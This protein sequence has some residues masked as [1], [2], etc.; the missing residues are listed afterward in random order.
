MQKPPLAPYIL[1]ALAMVGL[2]ITGYLAYFQY[3]N[4]IP[5]CAIGGCAVVLTSSYSKFFGVPW[6]YIGLVYYLYMLC[7]SV[8]LIIDPRSYGLRLGTLMYTGIGVLYSLQ[9]IFYVQLVLIGALCQ[10]CAMSAVTTL[11]LFVAAIWHWR[12]S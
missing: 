4:L 5:S 3:L 11:L 6:S 2:G 8:L 7:L 1:L 9:A 12:T 10:Y